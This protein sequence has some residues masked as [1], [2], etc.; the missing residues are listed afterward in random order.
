MAALDLRG[1][2]TGAI[3]AATVDRKNPLLFNTARPLSRLIA[4]FA[5]KVD[6]LHAASSVSTLGILTVGTTGSSWNGRFGVKP[7]DASHAYRR[8][9]IALSVAPG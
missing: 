3:R 9:S 4:A 1:V 5:S 7:L 6:V 8:L 2:N